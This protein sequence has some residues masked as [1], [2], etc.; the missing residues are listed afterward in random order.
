M[1]SGGGESEDQYLNFL[2]DKKKRAAPVSFFSIWKKLEMPLD[3]NNMLRSSLS[4]S[5]SRSLYHLLS[6]F[7][8]TINYL[9]ANHMQTFSSNHFFFKVE[10]EA[11]FFLENR[12]WG[13]GR[14]GTQS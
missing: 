7:G 1:G 13:G 3:V 4:N 12:V 10:W 8:V 9:Y 11:L 5:F 2:K 6:P 14:R